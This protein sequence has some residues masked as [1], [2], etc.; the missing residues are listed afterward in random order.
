MKHEK[1]YLRILTVAVFGS[2]ALSGCRMTD[3]EK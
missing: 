2:L 3:G 1:S